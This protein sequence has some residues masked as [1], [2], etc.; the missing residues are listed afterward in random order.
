MPRAQGLRLHG[1]C[2]VEKSCFV[3]VVALY[4]KFFVLLKISLN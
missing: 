1:T 3:A 4:E 2:N